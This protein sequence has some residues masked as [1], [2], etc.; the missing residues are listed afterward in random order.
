[1]FAGCT[2][3]VKPSR[4][5]VDP[6]LTPT[7]IEGPHPSLDSVMAD[8]KSTTRTLLDFAGQAEDAVKRANADKAA[9]KAVLDGKEKQ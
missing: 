5:N 4:P 8:S 2:A 7:V 9:A 6:F 3:A 1:M